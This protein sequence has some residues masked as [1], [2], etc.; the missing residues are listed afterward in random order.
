MGLGLW[1]LSL[2]GGELRTVGSGLL[3]LAAGSGVRFFS[4][5]TGDLERLVRRRRN[6]S[7]SSVVCKLR[8]S[9]DVKCEKRKITNL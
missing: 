3:L 4:V 5:L 1:S 6:K 9:S 2:S 7:E 8:A